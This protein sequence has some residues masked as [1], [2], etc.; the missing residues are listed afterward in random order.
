MRYRFCCPAA[1]LGAALSLS[2]AAQPTKSDAQARKLHEQVFT[3]DTHADT[4]MNLVKPGFDL[5]KDNDPAE[6]KLDLPKL[7][8]GGLDAVFWAVYMGQGPRTPAGNAAAKQEALRIFEAIHAAI[9]AHP[10][11]L[12]LATT[13]AEGVRIRKAGQRAIFIGIENGYPMGRDLGLLQ[14]YYNLGARYMTLCH[15]TNNDLCDSAT[16]PTGPEYQGLS[17]LGVQAVAEMNRLGMMVDISHTSDS[18]FYDV[19]RV[20]KAPIIASHSAARAI[21]NVPRNLSD[22]MLRALAKHGGVVQLSLFSPYVRPLPPDA[23]RDAAVQAF[24][25][26]WKIKN[27]LNVYS[28]PE[29]EQKQALAEMDELSKRFPVPLATVQDAANQI[30]HI[31]RVAGIDHVGIGGDFDG[32]TELDGLRDVGEYPNL[33]IELVRRGYSR[34]DIE[35]IWSGNLF[36]VMRAAEKARSAAPA[37]AAG[38]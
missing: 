9:K 20:S 33:T 30:D 10:T 6:A 15:G 38:K 8:R 19:L 26:K 28:L 34:R 35:K 14:Q 23:A 18:T 5:T 37:A 11:E 25:A 7:K 2:A 31:V 17:P 1:L 16:D 22:D 29:P 27:F 3:V 24:N 4:P 36:R 32:G 21:S 12:A 13:P